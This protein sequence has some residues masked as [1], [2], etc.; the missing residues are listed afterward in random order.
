MALPEKV[1]VSDLLAIATAIAE[2]TIKNQSK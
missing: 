2:N 1:L